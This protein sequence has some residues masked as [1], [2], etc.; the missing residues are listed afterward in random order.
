MNE[1]EKIKKIADKAHEERYDTDW[2]TMQ[3]ALY[4]I[5]EIVHK[6]KPRYKE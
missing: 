2:D 4:K 6:K 5:W 1:I 3:G